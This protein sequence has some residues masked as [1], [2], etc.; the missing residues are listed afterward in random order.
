MLRFFLILSLL[1]SVSGLH[2][3]DPTA[4]SAPIVL[5]ATQD[6]S[7][8]MA[9]G[10][11]ASYPEP[12]RGT[13]AVD[14]AT[15]PGIWGASQNR[16]KGPAG[17][18]QLTLATL[19]EN[20]GESSYRININQ[21]PVGSISQNPRQPPDAGMTRVTHTFSATW[22]NPGDAIKVLA[23]IHTNGLIPE[24]D[25]TA[26]SRGRWSEL[27]LTPVPTTTTP[28]D[29]RLNV[30][31]II[32]D[33][34]NTDLPSY[35]RPVVKT[36][37][38]DRITSRGVRF[39]NAYCQ[40]PLCGPSRTSFLTGLR[41][42]TIRIYGHPVSGRYQHS[43]ENIPHF[44]DQWPDLVTL[45][46]A[47]RYEGYY[48]AR[49][50][51]VFHYGVPG[52]IG[53]NGADDPISW[54]HV[55]NPAGRD[56]LEEHNITTLVPGNYGGTLSWQKAEGTDA[57]QTDGMIATAAVSLLRE[58]K[59]RPF[60]LAVGFFRPHTP[61]IAP[62]AY[63]DNYPTD[64]IELPTLSADDQSEVPAAPYAVKK[65]VEKSM[66]ADLRRQ[67]IQAYRA[68]VEFMDAQVGRVLDAL[69]SLDLQ[70]RTIVVMTS[71][72]GYHL[73]DHG[74]WQKRSLFENSARVPLVIA[75]PDQ[76]GN[77]HSTAAISEMVDLYP[78]LIDLAGLP[79]RSSL[80]G[81]SLA[82]IL[83]SPSSSLKDAAF[84]QVM[85]RAS[86]QAHSGY[87]VR[88]PRWRY[89]EWDG[90]ASG[91]QLFDMKADPGETL[92]LAS[93][94]VPEHRKAVSHLSGLLTAYRKP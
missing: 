21:R 24:G 31:F 2:G 68:S 42:D 89:I 1:V 85:I 22:I 83:R 74:L 91:V 80:D 12:K 76:P 66:S 14:A 63:F 35:G 18:Y 8:A 30:L 92:N 25:G 52:Q 58:I 43:Y 59:D 94:S 71:D 20:D 57:E 86:P 15:H 88:T 16:F 6:F 75:A 27:T 53:T 23:S 36:P 32:A 37:N 48:T 10:V 28:D 11:R 5:R 84:T 9:D 13:I 55:V 3:D 64:Q 26:Y 40:F 69:D 90:G 17:L 82:P 41:P 44:R 33:D 79:P 47:F 60:F 67:A 19:T 50:G 45:P 73:Y 7:I 29:E 4:V 34:L 70:K 39:D 49:I 77:G 87:S 72:H 38:I 65:D 46:Q 78:T 81:Q 51:K 93:S 61:Y 54:D 56:K 62:K